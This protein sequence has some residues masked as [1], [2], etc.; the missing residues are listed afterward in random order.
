MDNK[1][2]LGLVKYSSALLV[3]AISLSTYSVGFAGQ[4]IVGNAALPPPP[5]S[6]EKIFSQEETTVPEIEGNVALATPA[7]ENALEQDAANVPAK[8]D[9]F[10]GFNRAMFT[11]NDKLDTYILK[12]VAT[13][14]NKIMPKPLNKGVH[15][16]FNNID[17][18]TTIA[19]DVLQLHLYQALNDTWRFG[20]NTTVGIGGLFDIADR[21]NLKPYQN[22]FGMTLARWG[23]KDSTYLVLPF[24]G[25]NTFRDGVSIPV[26]YFAL[27]IYPYIQPTSTQYAI[28]AV[29][30]VDHR[31]QL[32]RYQDVFDEVMLDKYSFI[33]NA[34][35][36]RR[37]YQIEQNAKMSFISPGE[38]PAEPSRVDEVAS[39]SN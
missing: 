20:I 28:Y 38:T 22:D 31:A 1:K 11:F 2:R 33:R 27:S 12:P 8:T 30:V 15:N 24:F 18:L 34:Y 14:Y 37:A 6:Q 23:W 7:E 29:G 35:T 17:T 25:P 13:F 9:R 3:A 4:G 39:P 36:Q 10:E 21:I 19:N 5:P 26:D 32:L 16:V